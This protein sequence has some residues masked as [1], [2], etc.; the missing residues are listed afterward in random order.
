MR[1]Q[2]K[3]EVDTLLKVTQ[4]GHGGARVKK[5]LP[6]RMYAR[7]RAHPWLQEKQALGKLASCDL[8]Q[9]LGAARDL[10]E[11]RCLLIS[12]L[13]VAVEKREASL[14]SSSSIAYIHL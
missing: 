9:H 2:R 3:R 10:R 7:L 14:L 5:N 12:F 6:F 8:Q 4:L 11:K 1:K 13:L